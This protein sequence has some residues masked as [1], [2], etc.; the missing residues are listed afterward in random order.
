[1][2]MLRWIVFALC[3]LGGGQAFAQSAAV[4]RSTFFEA[5]AARADESMSKA[6][7]MSFLLICTAALLALGASLF[8]ALREHDRAMAA[9]NAVDAALPD[10]EE[11]R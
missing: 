10:E 8:L 11:T 2:S 5:G 6:T 4:E 9:M 3:F 1:M 7:Q